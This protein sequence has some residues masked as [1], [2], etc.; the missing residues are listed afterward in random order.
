MNDGQEASNNYVNWALDRGVNYFDIAPLYGDAQEKLGISLK[1][2]RKDIYLACKSARRMAGEIEKEMKRSLNLLKTDYFD[3]YQLHMLTSQEDIDRAFGPSGAMEVLV[4]AKENG[5]ARKLGI[6]AHSEE[7]ALKAMA[8]YDFDTVMFPLNFHMHKHNQMDEEP[9]KDAK[10]RGMGLLA[11]KPLISRRFHHRDE[12]HSSATP[13]SWCKAIDVSNTV[14]A[15]AAMKYALEMGADVLIPPGDFRNFS[16]VV[17]H[18][19]AII[20]NP[21]SDEEK[22]ALQQNFAENKGLLFFHDDG[23]MHFGW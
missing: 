19:E 17:D 15:V 10:Q 4:K 14:L 1:D 3:V 23:N 18:A 21:L 11:I 8:L 12:R 7:M 5:R 9:A 6:T 22:A 20:K 13:K 16:F 2:K